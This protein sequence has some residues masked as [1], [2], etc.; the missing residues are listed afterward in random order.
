[1]LFATNYASAKIPLQCT[2]K[3]VLCNVNGHT[4][5]KRESCP[6]NYEREA[7]SVFDGIDIN[8]SNCG[9]D[10]FGHGDTGT[11][12]QYLQRLLN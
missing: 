1:M 6:C 3:T 10:S 12:C 9:W 2:Y 5:I 7:K 4:I 8:L 11:I